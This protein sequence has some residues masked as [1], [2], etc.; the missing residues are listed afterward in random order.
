[1][2]A[3]QSQSAGVTVHCTIL[4]IKECCRLSQ[5]RY[6]SMPWNMITWLPQCRSSWCDHWQYKYTDHR[7]KTGDDRTVVLPM[8]N[9]LN[10]IWC[11]KYAEEHHRTSLVVRLASIYGENMSWCHVSAWSMIASLCWLRSSCGATSPA[12]YCWQ[13]G[14]PGCCCQTLEQFAW[15]RY[16]RRLA[17]D[18]PAST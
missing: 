17:G 12:V 16:F 11:W 6:D 15:Q 3:F 13:S 5:C 14:F 4:G 9:G 10:G 2:D 1:M 18:L 7:S 8:Q